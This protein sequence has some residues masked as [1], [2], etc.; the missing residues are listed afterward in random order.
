MKYLLG[1]DVGS[2]SV[3]AGLLDAESG[4]TVS[5]A[6][7]PSTEM[8]IRTPKP[9]WAEQD[10]EL[11]WQNLV[12]ACQRVMRESKASASAVIGIGISYQ[13]HGLV[14]VDKDLT[15]VRPAIIWCDSR[16]VGIGDRAF[17]QLGEEF[18]FGHLLNS[19]G[20]F[21]ASKLRWVKENEPGVF[22]RIHAILL[23]GD[24][25]ALKL[26]GK[27]TTTASG[28]S[29]GILW[30]YS[31]QGVADVLLEHFEIPK[32]VIPERV[33]TFGLQGTLT[34]SAAKELGLAEGTPLCY[35]AGDQPNNAFSL[36]AANPGE[37]ASTAG[38]S[39]VIY[40]VTDKAIADKQSRVNTFLH[41]NHTRERPRYGVLLCV[42][43]TGIMNSWLRQNVFGTEFSY[44]AM[45]D[46]ATQAPPGSDALVVLPFGNGAERMLGNCQPGASFNGLDLNRHRRPHLCRAVQEGIV[47]ALGYGF[48]TLKQLGIEPRVIR[49]GNA[50]M[51]QSDVFCQTFAEVTGAEL[52]LFDVDGALGAARAAGIGSGY[53]TSMEDAFQYVKQLKSFSPESKI[54]R[55]VGAAFLQW[56]EVLHKQL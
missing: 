56:K 42:N 11:W 53:Y 17:T 48:E 45:N 47:F 4:D 35:R 12:A 32:H 38:T 52:Q 40:A 44:A 7:V 51:F 41:V 6:S 13:M 36:N 46:L 30:D 39:G 15:V 50:N 49:A 1:F 18:C 55:E 29:E 8:E 54:S 31:K 37:V 2:S 22:S 16:A 23:P 10:P 26:T 19:P 14:A 34:G 43:G 20:N 27:T 25:I 21:T 28:L 9:G 24:Y 5:V 33:P 3:K